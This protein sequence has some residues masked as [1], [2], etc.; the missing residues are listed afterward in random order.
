MPAIRDLMARTGIETRHLEAIFIASGPGGFSALRVGMSTAKAMAVSLGV[1]LVAVG[2]LDAEVAPYLGLGYPVCG[3]IG[4]GRTRV[5]VGSYQD[6]KDPKYDVLNTQD[7]LPSVQSGTLYC[8][9]AVHELASELRERLGN[10]SLM[11]DAPPPTRRAGLIAAMGYVKWQ[12]GDVDDAL[13]MEPLYL[14]SSQVDAANRAWSNT[15]S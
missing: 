10:D 8:G 6:G 4:A 12:A 14:R 5:Y 13:T 1:P 11:A 15:G 9:E 3:I 2:T 7:F